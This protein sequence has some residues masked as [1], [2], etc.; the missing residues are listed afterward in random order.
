MATPL[1]T[2]VIP[3]Y[4]RPRLLRRA[5]LSVL[6]Q[7]YSHFE[8]HVYDNA[9][10]DETREVVES[11]AT[12]DPRIRYH[13]HSENIGLV[14][15]FTSGMERV[16]TPFF[17]LL[18]DDDLA[19]PH[20]FEQG[21][22]VLAKHPD[23]ILFAG[24]TIRV[25]PQAEIDDVPLAR[26]REGIYSPPEGL[27]EILKNGHPDFTGTLFRREVLSQVGT[28]D[29]TVGNPCDV[30]YFCRCAAQYPIAVARTCCAV[31][32]EHA[33]SAS[34][35]AAEAEEPY[36]LSSSWLVWHKIADKIL[37]LH[38]VSETD[39]RNAHDIIMHQ[40][41]QLIFRRGCKAAAAGYSCHAEKAACVLQD[42]LG[43]GLRPHIVRTLARLSKPP[44][45]CIL[46]RVVMIAR[47]RRSSW[48]LAALLPRDR[49]K[50][51]A[52]ADAINADLEAL[53]AL[54][55]QR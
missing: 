45:R 10:G 3:T 50:Y 15:N 6:K 37:V 35:V 5:I 17:N 39:R 2:T 31:V 55:S 22:S 29:P 16:A 7:T 13:C 21:I 46:Q 11:L 40:T 27:F 9:S 52:L 36:G 34:L 12:T 41:G 24:A 53:A 30:D 33:S 14:D 1:I 43:R 42:S 8:I 38:S 4:R 25:T 19:L 54:R 48:Q 26:W 47:R 49:Q 18:S 20:F 44:L 51:A 23:A 32:F 28:L